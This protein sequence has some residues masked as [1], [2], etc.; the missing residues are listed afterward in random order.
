MKMK[1]AEASRSRNT[2]EFCQALNAEGKRCEARRMSGSSYCFFHSPEKEQARRTARRAGGLKNRIAVLPRATPDV[3][4]SHARDIQRL[5]A[6]TINQV[7]RGELDP[8]AANCIGYLSGLL[9]KSFEQ[10]EIESRLATLESA[11]NRPA[12]KDDF[13]LD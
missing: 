1:P 2:G 4:L 13:H 12:E 5:L 3:Q 9:A 8:K 11:V 10:G 7:R 6:E